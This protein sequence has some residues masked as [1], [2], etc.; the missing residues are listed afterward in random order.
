MKQYWSSPCWLG[1]AH[2]RGYYYFKVSGRNMLAHC[3]AY[4]TLVGPIPA[5]LELDHLCRN[6][7]CYNPAHLE[8]VTHREN[9]L[10]GRNAQSEKTHC[11]KGHNY[12]KVATDGKRRCRECMLA[13][14][15]R[16]KEKVVYREYRK[17]HTTI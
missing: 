15:R 1:R 10:R 5:G 11:P 12:E 7:N 13:A 6:R 16:W 8:P 3:L 2:S 4:R 9:C 17:K 14:S